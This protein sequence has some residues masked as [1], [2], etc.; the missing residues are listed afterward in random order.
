MLHALSCRAWSSW[1]TLVTCAFLTVYSTPGPAAAQPTQDLLPLVLGGEKF[2]ESIEETAELLSGVKSREAL[3]ALAWHPNGR[4][5][6][7]GGAAG[8]VALWDLETGLESFRLEDDSGPVETLSFSFDGRWL[9]S[10]S[11]D[12]T[13]R[14]WDLKADRQPRRWSGWTVAF[15]PR[16]DLLAIGSKDGTVTILDPRTGAAKLPAWSAH[17]ERIAALA[18]HPNGHALATG[19]WDRTIKLWNAA[20]GKPLGP[21]IKGAHDERVNAVSWGPKGE[22]LAS[23][24][25]DSTVRVWEVDTGKMVRLFEGHRLAATAVVWHP[26]GHMVASASRDGSVRLWSY[27]A[28]T[29]VAQ[30]ENF[31]DEVFALSPSPSGRLLAAGTREGFVGIWS[32]SSSQLVRR[33]GGGVPLVKALAFGNGGQSLVAGSRGAIRLW[34]RNSKPAHGPW[35]FPLSGGKAPRCLALSAMGDTLAAGFQD[36]PITWWRRAADGARRF[37]R[38]APLPAQTSAVAALAFSPDGGL[39]A[40][41]FDDGMVQVLDLSTRELYGRF[42]QTSSRDNDMPQQRVQALAFSSDGRRLV[43]AFGGG[44]LYLW[45]LE[46]KDLL[47]S[48]S[49]RL[50]GDALAVHFISPTR[51]GVVL[52]GGEV[53]VWVI[54]QQHASLAGRIDRN[55]LSAAAFGKAGDALATVGIGEGVVR[56]WSPCKVARCTLSSVLL[57]GD[58]GQWIDCRRK[59]RCYRYDDG[60]L[61]LRQS[62]SG[63]FESMPLQRAESA[64]DLQLAKRLPDQVRLTD[65]ELAPLTLTLRNPGPQRAIW[66]KVNQVKSAVNTPVVFHPPPVQV[67]IEPGETAE[68]RGEVS[69]QSSYEYPTT[70]EAALDLVVTSGG[71]KHLFLDPIQVINRVPKVDWQSA[72]L[73]LVGNRLT[74]DLI[75]IG[76]DSFSADHVAIRS[77]DYYGPFT[78]DAFLELAAGQRGRFVWDPRKEQAELS[79]RLDFVVYKTQL[80]AHRWSFADRRVLRFP[81][82]RP[83]L[84]VILLLAA[85]LSG[86]YLRTRILFRQQAGSDERRDGLWGW[87]GGSSSEYVQLAIVFTDVVRSTHLLNEIKAAAWAIVRNQHF[88]K[89][90]TLAERHGGFV[91]K[92]T[93]DGRMIAFRSSIE[94]LKFAVELEGRTGH[95]KITVRVGVHVGEVQVDRDDAHGL[96]VHTASRVMEIAREGGVCV[97]D[98]VKKDYDNTFHETEQIYSWMEIS[99]DVGQGRLWEVRFRTDSGSLAGE[100]IHLVE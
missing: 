33:L 91:V 81:F 96:V 20:D 75:S 26:D 99:E 58:R 59:G 4:E 39:L 21:T 77:P 50:A 24:S 6:A 10:S 62:N 69:L 15:S 98:Q 63:V 56:I 97:T 60:T 67:V 73:S 45:D 80:P 40:A 46:S 57:G 70:Q 87:L 11:D 5:V 16:A 12:G 90:D 55:G 23:A 89:T 3:Y 37:D 88:D 29:E 9:A 19:S 64:P 93:G 92:S 53:F 22:F 18:W 36:G 35:T 86:T 42:A 43:G 84:Y 74:V 1:G 95:E 41:G 44:G 100:D 13:V 38:Q 65:G 54:G 31:G 51:V 34:D 25:A 71:G 48:G 52:R 79:R 94:A 82:D 8:V 28:G 7:T 72:R 49:R 76:D 85:L 32:F 66:V 27:V 17:G 61:L 47:S 83:V 14:L 30:L 68:L 2:A 78:T